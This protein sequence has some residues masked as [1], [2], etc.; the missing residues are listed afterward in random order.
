MNM[1]YQMQHSVIGGNVRKRIRVSEDALDAYM[2]KHS[3]GKTTITKSVGST[4]RLER[5]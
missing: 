2:V 4:R 1:M 3:I 5:R